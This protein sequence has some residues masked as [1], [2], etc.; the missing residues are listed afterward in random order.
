MTTTAGVGE[1]TRPPLLLAAAAA[2]AAS[3]S[4]IPV[5]YLAVRAVEAGTEG[6]VATLLRPRVLELALNSVALAASVTATCLVLGVASAWLLSRWR[7]PAERTILLLS[8]LPLAVPS[9]LVAYGWLVWSPGLNGFWPSWAVLTAVCVPYVTLPV[10][11]AWRGS[12]GDL[13]AVARTLGR[14]PIRSFFSATWPQVRGAA[15]AGSL[16]VGLYSLAEFGAVSMLRFETL[17]WGI[18]ASYSASFDRQQAA[19]LALVLVALALIVV[20]AERRARGQAVTRVARPL[21]R[22]VMPR[23]W[24]WAAL[25]VVLAAPV[26]SVTVPVLGL[27]VRLFSAES[28]RALDLPRFASA[29]GATLGLAVV[30][31]L[32]VLVFALPI[33][34]LTAR[35]RDR[36]SRG[37]EGIGYLGHALPGIVVGLSLVFFGLAVVPWA[38]QSLLM[39]LFAYVVLFMPR[40]IGSARSGIAAVAPALIDVS[41]TLGD[42]PAASWRRVTARLAAPNIAIGCLLAAIAIMKE[43]PAT[44]LLRPTSVHTLAT[45]LWTRTA[46]AEYGGAAPYAAALLLVASVPAVLL[47]TIRSTAREDES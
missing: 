12:S 47:S 45:E 38:Y 28:I 33:A 19:V 32:L 3:A 44:L 40:A 6:F 37:I 15:L 31:S 41:R 8:A 29:V 42:T 26:V 1:R 13:E 7:L 4:L 30:G 43:L 5:V 10:A 27:G 22:G 34:A 36:L 17:T 9:Y 14:G 25:A 2:L 23:R 20:W 35:Y 16:L 11:A 46:A 18:N 21:P 39:L 24:L